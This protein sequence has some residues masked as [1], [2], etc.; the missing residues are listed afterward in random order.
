M[1]TSKCYPML[2]FKKRF[3]NFV[4]NFKIF[5]S[6]YTLKVKNGWNAINC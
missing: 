6:L 4:E 5:F 3:T 1:R 2:L